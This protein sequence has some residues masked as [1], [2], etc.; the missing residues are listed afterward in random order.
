M[1][2]R[3]IALNLALDVHENRNMRH[4][5]IIGS[6]Q[7]A[8]RKPDVTLIKQSK[9]DVV[10]AIIFLFSPLAIDGLLSFEFSAASVDPIFVAS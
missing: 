6:L 7:L 5:A 1:I 4:G 2:R 9:V 10:V 8:D 3:S